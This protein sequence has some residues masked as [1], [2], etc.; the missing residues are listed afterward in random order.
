MATL[1][2]SEGVSVSQ[3]LTEQV[4]KPDLDVDSRDEVFESLVEL[5][6]DQGEVGD[7]TTALE[8]IRD[9]EEILSTG[10]GNGVAIPHAKTEAVDSLV[11]A[12]GRVPDGVDFKSLDGKP[13]RL[14]FLLLSP[15][16]EAGLHVRALARISRMLKNAEFREQM[17]DAEDAEEIVSVIENEET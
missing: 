12:F 16:E 2:R 14:I 1:E 5:L 8:D 11:A 3:L 10:I 13:A 4:I 9:R 7:A 6:E 15:Q 17:N